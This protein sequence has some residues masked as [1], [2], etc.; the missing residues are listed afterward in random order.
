MAILA[1]KPEH[2]KSIETIPEVSIPLH[3]KLACC[4]S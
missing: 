2:V 1:N 3:K 4:A